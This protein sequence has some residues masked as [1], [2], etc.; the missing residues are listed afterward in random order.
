MTTYNVMTAIQVFN[1]TILLVLILLVL[2][3]LLLMI[4]M[5]RFKDKSDAEQI[6][7]YETGRLEPPRCPKPPI[8][9]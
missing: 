7:T 8:Q 4:T 3:I 2:V 9:K 6:A 5:I 1:I